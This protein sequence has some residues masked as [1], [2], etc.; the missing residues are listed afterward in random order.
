VGVLILVRHGRTAFNA[1]GQLVGR[2]DPPLDEVGLTQAA[3]IGDALKG[4]D[5][6]IASP[7][8]R[9]R[10]TAEYIGSP[11][12]VDERWIEVDY[13]MYDGMEL[14]APAASELWERWRLDPAFVPPGGESLVQ[15][16]ERV[17]GAMEE[18]V[19]EVATLDVVV[20]SHVSPIKAA[21][22]W[23]LHADAETAW[24]AHLD[25]ASISRIAITPRGAVLRSFNET[26]HLS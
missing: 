24:R 4:I 2:L 11:V 25:Q 9:A 8:L 14:G 26:W 5:R 21:V 22:S 13:G 18:L 6:V 17:A 1:A 19:A 15:M 7:L 10:Q 23:V 20:V 16:G 12:E 3:A